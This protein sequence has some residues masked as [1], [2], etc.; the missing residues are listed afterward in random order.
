[1]TISDKPSEGAM[2]GHVAEIA[3]FGDRTRYVVRTDA[4]K[5]LL[6]SRANVG[7]P[8]A[9]AVGDATFVSYAADAAVSVAQ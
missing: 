5:P 1:M 7:P 2:A 6:I 8:L 4:G 9:L 3:Y